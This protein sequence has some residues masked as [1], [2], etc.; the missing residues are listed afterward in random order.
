MTRPSK[1]E[2]ERRLATR[3]LAGFV[4]YTAID[5]H[6]RPDLR[7]RRVE[8]DIA[9]E[10]T[11]Y[12]SQTPEGATGRPRVAVEAVWWRRFAPIIEN[13]RRVNPG[14]KSVMA[15]FRFGDCYLPGKS[16]AAHHRPRTRRRSS[17]RDD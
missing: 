9:L 1:K 3:F 16:E 2:H 10:V 14:L 15:H 8:G 7:I 12:H 11:E 6:E 5:D 17:R 4:D 13:E